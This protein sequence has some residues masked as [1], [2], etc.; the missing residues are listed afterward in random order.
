MKKTPLSCLSNKLVIVFMAAVLAVMLIACSPESSTTTS[1]AHGSPVKLVFIVQPAGAVAGS[2]FTRQPVVSIQDANGNTVSGLW[3]LVTITI[4]G[5]AAD[6]F[7]GLF[8]GTTVTSADGVYNFKELAI[9]KAG[10]YTL[11]AACNGLASAVSDPLNITPVNGAKLVF[12]KPVVGA[13]AGAAFTTQP[14]VTVLDMYGNTA[15]SS[16]VKVDLSFYNITP[17]SSEAVLSGVSTV[18]AVNGIADFKGLS[19]D[20]TGS[21]L[22]IA[23]GT[24]LISAQSNPFDITPGAPV[25]L[26]FNTQPLTT[27]PG[28]ELTVMPPTIAVVVQD[29]YGNTVS[30]SSA[31]I[32]LTITPNT[33]ASGAVLSGVTK[34]KTGY[35]VVNFGG[36][37]IDKIGSGYTLTATSSGLASAVSD[38][39]DIVAVTQ[40]VNSS[41]TTSP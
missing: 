39:F 41:N 11:T 7:S 26:F 22:L 20:I 17:E 29:N 16:T 14:Q 38:R 25:R 34:L 6:S 15:T 1:A 37:S 13:S 27:T 18:N 36:L 24:G 35:G 5:N 40:T 21:Y 28:A 10:T 12:T 4:T 19:I 3:K 32:T 31:E 33:G 9:D 30:G 8:G 23:S 2:V